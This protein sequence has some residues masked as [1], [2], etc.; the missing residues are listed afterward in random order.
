MVDT[1]NL[2]LPN[3]STLSDEAIWRVGKRLCRSTVEVCAKS[4][5]QNYTEGKDRIRYG[6]NVS[7][8][9]SITD[10][11]KHIVTCQIVKTK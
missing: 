2:T 7:R 8:I 5:K 10:S 11:R 9:E 6:A 3:P 1:F 4:I